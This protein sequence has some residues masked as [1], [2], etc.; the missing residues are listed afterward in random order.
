MQLQLQQTL[1]DNI[2]LTADRAYMAGGTHSEGRGGA[3]GSNMLFLGMCI[4][5]CIWYLHLVLHLWHSAV[6]SKVVH[7]VLGRGA[8]LEIYCKLSSSL[9]E[10]NTS[11]AADSFV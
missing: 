3:C 1:E 10:F 4:K 5:Y 6:S 8:L 11:L 9:L 7:L 2:M